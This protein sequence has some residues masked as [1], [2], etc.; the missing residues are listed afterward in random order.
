MVLTGIMLEVGTEGLAIKILDYFTHLLI[1][2]LL[3]LYQVECK[4]S[5]E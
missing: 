1:L 3:C 5:S 4:I 2:G